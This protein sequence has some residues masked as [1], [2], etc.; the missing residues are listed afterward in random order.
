MAYGYAY[1]NQMA[2]PN[3]YF[4]ANYTPP[5]LPMNAAQQQIQPQTNVNWIYVNGIQGARDHIVQPGQTAWMMDNNDPV[6]YVKAV[7]MMGS[8]TFK[9]MLL[10][11]YNISNP[12]QN[13]QQSA[14]DT[15]QFVKADDFDKLSA[16]MGELESRLSTLVNEIGGLNT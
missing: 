4:N 3:S 2:V 6:I 15:S 16:R 10:T 5:P 7:D 8:T 13:V 12:P 11:D 9:A 14:V 1:G